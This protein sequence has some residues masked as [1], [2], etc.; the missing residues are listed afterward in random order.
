[1]GRAVMIREE[2]LPS[3]W[4]HETRLTGQHH[5][6]GAVPGI[7]DLLGAAEMPMPFTCLGI[8][9]ARARAGWRGWSAV[10]CAS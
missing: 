4:R 1:M 5:K 2:R 6:L 7:L 3:G 9:L 10:W 8:G